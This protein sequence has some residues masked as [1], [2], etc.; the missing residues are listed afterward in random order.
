MQKMKKS[1]AITILTL[2]TLLY[3]VASCTSK[4]ARLG[5]LDGI[6][7]LM[8][9]NPQAAY[10]SLCHSKEQMTANGPKEVSMRYRLL[11][12]KAQNKLY[13]QMPSDFLFQDVV[14]YYDAN[15][16]I[17]EKM[18]ARYLYGCIYRD[19]KNKAK[20]MYYFQEAANTADTLSR[21]CN[22]SILF[23]IYGQIGD[24][25]N[26]LYL[27]HN[28]IVAYQK[29]SHYAL[30]AN[31]KQAW[32]QGKVQIAAVYYTFGDITKAIK[33]SNQC[34]QL[35]RKEGM[36]KEAIRVLPI[37]IYFL[38]ERHQYNQAKH[39]MD[40]YEC[41]SGLF[42]KN[43]CIQQGREHYYKAKGLY[44][45]G[46]NRIDS[47]EYYFRKLNKAGHIRE[48][49][50]G[51]L[52]VYAKLCLKDSILKYSTL[53]E[54]ENDSIINSVQS[55]ATQQV[56]NL[57]NHL[58]LQK[59][60]QRNQLQATI[61]KIIVISVCVLF[62]LIVLCLFF[63]YKEKETKRLQKIKILNTAYAQCQ[64]Q[65]AQAI[66]D[67][68]IAQ[69]NIL[70]LVEEKQKQITGLQEKIKNLKMLQN[71]VNKKDMQNVFRKSEIAS[72][73]KQMAS[74]KMGTP[75]PSDVEWQTFEDS[76]AESFPRLYDKIVQAK[77][78]RQE[79][80]VCLLILLQFDNSTMAV[81]MLTNTNVIC[82]VKKRTNEKLFGEASATSLTKNLIAAC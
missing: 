80:Q 13:L 41:E 8:E 81:L 35:Y 32:I 73:F 54:K 66:S 6:D 38:L 63:I 4:D 12:A 43:G 17:N 39:L 19:L 14:N 7:S 34:E 59:D 75:K 70:A 68:N 11:M 49:L 61:W 21:K 5:K 25:Y 30:K 37:R 29:S 52:T 65:L 77:L 33:I 69:T 44:Y 53:C 47:A 9:Q 20:A 57:Q 78:A 46:I 26:S 10:D 60:I 15:G 64:K 16:T 50:N 58:I 79:L 24:L 76:F 42:D 74:P 67:C 23:R 40:T 56:N 2:T 31:D 28:A 27:R 45:L 72:G 51:L 3:M 82:N 48:A 18:E 22:Y 36:N 1:V 62:L 71:R 55:E